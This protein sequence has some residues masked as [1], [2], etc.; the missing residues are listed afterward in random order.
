KGAVHMLEQEASLQEP[1]ETEV[2]FLLQDT[3]NLQRHIAAT[4]AVSRG[5]FFE[6]NYRFD[7]SNDSLLK[8]ASLLR[9]RHDDCARLTFKAKPRQTDTQFKTYQEY[10]VIVSDF[11]TMTRILERLGYRRRQV[12]EKWRETFVLDDTLLCIDT[13][14]F[15]NF[16]EIE[17]TRE[18][19]TQF[20]ARLGFDW[21]LRIL[22]NYLEIFTL[23]KHR[24]NLPFNDVT[25]QNFE[26]VQIDIEP[27]IRQ[28]T[29][30]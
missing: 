18:A 24:F 2:K 26:S 21:E 30:S 28:I 10:E 3:T 4:G 17:G 13:M 15:G 23:I 11:E 27:V 7:D 6:T 22:A 1:L 14:P 12:Y 25:F 20:A 5:R 29:A 8:N 16:L 19:I 9:L